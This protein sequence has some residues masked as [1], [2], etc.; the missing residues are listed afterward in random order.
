MLPLG[1]PALLRRVGARPP[2]A[3]VFFCARPHD[4]KTFVRGC[5][6]CRQL[7]PFFPPVPFSPLGKRGGVGLYQRGYT[8][9][10]LRR[11]LPPPEFGLCFS[12]M[13]HPI[14]AVR[15]RVRPGGRAALDLHRLMGCAARQKI[16][17]DNSKQ[18]SY[19]VRVG[20][21][22]VHLMHSAA[23]VFFVNWFFPLLRPW[24]VVT[25]ATREGFAGVIF[26]H[27]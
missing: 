21:C 13:R 11:R 19:I 6:L 1:S 16:A 10:R 12:A 5:S 17:L 20:L 8:P 2:Q 23:M 25:P 4:K 14:I 15:S 18:M 22:R 27:T 24:P 7:L 3:A 9:H 26:L